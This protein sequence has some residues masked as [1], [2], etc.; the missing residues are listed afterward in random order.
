[1]SSPS[2]RPGHRSKLPA[3][4][5]VSAESGAMI[6][7]PGVEAI[8]VKDTVETVE[9]KNAALLQKSDSQSYHK[10]TG[11]VTITGRTMALMGFL[12]G[13]TA[14]SAVDGYQVI[15]EYNPSTNVI[16][17]PQTPITEDGG[18]AT[19]EVV[20]EYG[21]VL[22]QVLGTPGAGE[23]TVSGTTVTLGG[24]AA[25]TDVFACSLTASGTAAPSGVL[26]VVDF[27]RRPSCARK[28]W[29]SGYTLSPLTTHGYEDYRTEVIELANVVFSGDFPVFDAKEEEQSYELNFTG[30]IAARGDLRHYMVQDPTSE[31]GAPV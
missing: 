4:F 26:K 3:M 29:M 7:L 17:L 14:D 9:F 27:T 13:Y 2:R 25:D 16:T 21:L 23:Y 22:L 10:L 12:N 20:D 28:V 30:N 5:W 18:K 31:W 24:T 11:T 6:H 8:S 19:V 15:G 1:M